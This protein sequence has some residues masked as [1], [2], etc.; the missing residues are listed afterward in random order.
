MFSISLVIA[1]ESTG[2]PAFALLP[3]I[4][5]ALIDT[6]KLIPFLFVTFLLME[7]I[8]KKAGDRFISVLSKSGKFSLA[9]PPIGAVL[10]ILPQGGFSAA[11]SNLYAGRLI[12]VGTLIAVY[13]STSDEA[14][15]ILLASPNHMGD[16]GRLLLTKFIIA[17]VFGFLIDLL[18]KIFDKKSEIADFEDF[19]DDCGCKE[20]GVFYAAVKHTLSITVFIL[21]LN[22]AI[23]I[24][25]GVVGEDT[26]FRFIQSFGVF[27]PAAAALVGLIPNCAA[28]V[29][30]TELFINGG[31]TFGSTVA[32]LCSGA[33]VGL[34]VLCRT[35][36]NV[37]ENILIICLV[38]ALGVLAGS[39]VNFIF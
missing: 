5:E 31:L 33:G 7:F 11:A 28:S 22:L 2:V 8:E 29:L 36:K 37:K 21:I 20:H 39:I 1:T 26:F 16:I 35:N 17:I 13:M 32:G 23:G 14:L 18:L 38:Y 19:C 34:L 30:V 6:A 3:T 24:I 4:E 9:G 25:I 10:G 15:P 12:S 27:Q